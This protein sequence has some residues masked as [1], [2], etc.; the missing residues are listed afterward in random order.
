[1]KSSDKLLND[2]ILG[3]TL[4]AVHNSQHLPTRTEHTKRGGGGGRGRGEGER[5]G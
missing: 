1:M 2:L 5:E 4:G 3:Q